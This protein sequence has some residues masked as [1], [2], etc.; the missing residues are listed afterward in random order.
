MVLLGDAEA[1]TKAATETTEA[2]AEAEGGAVAE[3]AKV[4]NFIIRSFNR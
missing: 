2:E 3:A 1:A 4:L